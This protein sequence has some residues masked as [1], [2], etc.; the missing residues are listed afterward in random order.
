LLRGN[1]VNRAA[2]NPNP[3]STQVVTASVDGNAQVWDWTG[4]KWNPGK[5]LR[6]ERAVSDA[7]FSPDG[8]FVVTASADTAQ[9]WE[10]KT[11]LRTGPPL[12]H[13]APVD[14]AAFSADGNWVITRSEDG[15]ARVW[16][17]FGGQQIGL[18]LGH[19]IPILWAAFSPDGKRVVMASADGTPE[20]PQILMGNPKKDA[21]LMADV[22]QFLSGYEV[23]EPRRLVPINDWPERFSRLREQASGSGSSKE[24]AFAA[25]LQKLFPRQ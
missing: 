22:A 11:G 18:P 13:N 3:N 4:A 8:K 10:V 23:T 17:T 7:A 16:Q 21:R 9:V 14:R 15:K 20:A 1:P 25:F 6:H 19:G 12:R 5:L 24:P 2:F